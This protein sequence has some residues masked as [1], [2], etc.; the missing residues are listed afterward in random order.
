MKILIV[1]D[2]ATWALLIKIWL[3]K[4]GFE[5]DYAQNGYEAIAFLQQN[6][7]DFMITDISMPEMSG[8][9]LVDYV[10]KHYKILIVVMSNHDEYISLMSDIHF[11]FQKPNSFEKFKEILHIINTGKCE[12]IN[13]GECAFIKYGK[14]EVSYIPECI[15]R[16][17]KID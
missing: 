8:F 1:D 3:R 16:E 11:K 13:N 17:A 2:T 5:F 10:K 4:L 15:I 12:L 9:K 14:C 6:K 7:Y